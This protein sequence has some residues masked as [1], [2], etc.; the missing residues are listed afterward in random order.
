MY[1]VFDESLKIILSDIPFVPHEYQGIS[2]NIP[3]FLDLDTNLNLFNRLLFWIELFAILP[4]MIF[5]SWI[6]WMLSSISLFHKNI[7]VIWCYVNVFLMAGAASRIYLVMIQLNLV[8]KLEIVLYLTSFIRIE[9]YEGF[10]LIIP[11]VTIER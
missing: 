8:P 4:S 7:T 6:I 2:Y 3:I 10:L 9:C 11:V 5:V 1:K